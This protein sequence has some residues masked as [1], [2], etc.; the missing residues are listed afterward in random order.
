MSLRFLLIDD[1]PLMCKGAR[2]AL[3]ESWPDAHV[4]ERHDLE[5]AL[6]LLDRHDYDLV[7]L[8]LGLPDSHGTE[9]L[10]ACKGRTR[11]PVLVCSRHGED[12]FA[13]STLRAGAVGYL[14][15]SRSVEEFLR[16]VHRALAGRRYISERLAERL[17]R[18][19]ADGDAPPHVLLSAQERRVLLFLADG[20]TINDAAARMGISPKTVSTYR[21]RLLDKLGLDSNAALVRYCLEHG[22]V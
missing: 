20:L 10:L 13:L 8:D 6:K 4:D 11:A 14:P 19:E 17:V 7:L 15:K 18:G 16:A 12:Q 2:H 9:A 3:L 1:H 22:L 21:S 5:S